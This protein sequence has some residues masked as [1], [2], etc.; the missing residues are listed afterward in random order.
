MSLA[1]AGRALR[2]LIENPE[3]TSQV[4]RL[5]EALRGAT[6]TRITRRMRRSPSGRRLLTDKPELLKT[7]RNRSALEAMSA[8][9]LGE[10]YLAFCASEGIS[11]DGLVAASEAGGGESSQDPDEEWVGERMRDAHDLWHVVTGYRG[12]L[13]G[14][15]SL[16]AFTFAQTLNRGIG[17]IVAVALLKAPDMDTKRLILDGFRRGRHANWLPAVAW[18]TLLPLPLERVRELLNVGP[19]PEYEPVRTRDLEQPMR[20]I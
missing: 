7:I 11:A 16:L 19:P 20:L 8:G 10:R 17:L 5:I 12:D 2:A 15:A 14:E 13:I 6:G 3:D 4:F 18:E 1:Q 9:S